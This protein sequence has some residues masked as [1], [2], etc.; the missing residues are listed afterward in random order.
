LV[1]ALLSE[2]EEL[3][4]EAAAP[5]LGADELLLEAL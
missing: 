5:S 1:S 3:F 4:D 2:L